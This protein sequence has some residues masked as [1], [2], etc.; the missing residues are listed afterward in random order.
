[1]GGE[2]GGVALGVIAAVVHSM[3]LKLLRSCVLLLYFF[4]WAL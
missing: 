4:V 1:M 2:K 3:A